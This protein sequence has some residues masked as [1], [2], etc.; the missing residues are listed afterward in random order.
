MAGQRTVIVEED[1]RGCFGK[2]VAAVLALFSGV[3]LLNLGAG[4][5]EIPDILPI[6]GN[7]DETVAAWIFFSSLGYLGIDIM[8]DPKRA[9]KFVESKAEDRKE[10]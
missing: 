10:V 1:A 9:R 2:G 6:V 8:P 4:L 3:W 5:I 7:L